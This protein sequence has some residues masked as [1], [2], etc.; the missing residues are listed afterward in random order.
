M[1]FLLKTLAAAAF[2]AALGAPALAQQTATTPPAPLPFCENNPGFGDWDFWVG[3][4]NVYSNDGK[5][6]FQ[7]TNSITRHYNDCLLMENW[8]SA[9]GNGGFSINYFNPVKDEWRQVWVANGY[10]IDYTGG[11]NEDGAMV[12]EGF[13][14]GYRPNATTPFRGTWSKLEGTDVRQFFEIHNAEGEWTT[15]FDGLYVRAETDPNP[16]EGQ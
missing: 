2:L 7:G 13:I 4:W 1:K 16:P 14:Y 8:M 6:V 3:D 5:R 9:G 12:L 11:L 10:S 15:W